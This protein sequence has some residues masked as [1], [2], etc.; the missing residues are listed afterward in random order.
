MKRTRCC[1]LRRRSRRIARRATTCRACR[2]TFGPTH[3]TSGSFTVWIAKGIFGCASSIPPTGPI[4]SSTGCPTITP[5]SNPVTSCLTWWNR[6]L[7]ELVEEADPE[8][9]D[10]LF[11]G[12]RLDDRE[13]E[14]E[15]NRHRT[16]HRHDNAHADAGSDAIVVDVDL[17]S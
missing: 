8:A 12:P 11:V 17:R 6:K 10:A 5:R 4:I 2:S 7:P 1:L 13:A 16:E 3:T 15:S 9:E 14:I